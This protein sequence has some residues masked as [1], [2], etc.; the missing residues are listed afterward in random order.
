[1]R[2]DP[3]PDQTDQKDIARYRFRVRIYLRIM[4]NRTLRPV[5]RRELSDI[6]FIILCEYPTYEEELEAKRNATMYDEFRGL[7]YVDS[8]MISEWRVKRCLVKWNLHLK[9]KSFCKRLHRTG[10][11]LRPDSWEDFRKLPPLVRKV[12]TQKL[13]LSLGPP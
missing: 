12:I 11:M 10:S 4:P 3:S 1:M 2:R 13:W 5:K 6:D 9:L 7:H 8:D